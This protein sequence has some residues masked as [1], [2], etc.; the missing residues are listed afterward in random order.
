[1]GAKTHIVTHF[2]QSEG[3]LVTDSGA[4]VHIGSADD[5]LVAYEL[6]L[7]GLSHCLYSTFE[8]IGE[9]MQLTYGPVSVQ[10]T[11]VKRDEKVATLE[12]CSVEIE[13]KGVEDRDKFEKA[14][15]IATRYCSIYNTISKVA[16][17]DWKV[18]FI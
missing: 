10:V 14:I 8:S 17:M 6:L 13:A 5:R 11:G 4:K 2:D 18:S 9:K 15:E 16:T 1:M 3:T 12:T 7:G